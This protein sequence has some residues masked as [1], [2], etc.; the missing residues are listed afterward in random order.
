MAECSTSHCL[1]VVYMNVMEP[2]MRRD[3]ERAILAA[4]T[5]DSVNSMGRH[6]H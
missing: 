4:M 5:R 2:E 6:D 1:Y 3:A